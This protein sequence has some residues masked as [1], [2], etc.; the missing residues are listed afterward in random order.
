MNEEEYNAYS[1]LVVFELLTT[2]LKYLNEYTT[3]YPTNKSVAESFSKKPSEN[4]QS[5]LVN[6]YESNQQDVDDFTKQFIENNSTELDWTRFLNKYKTFPA[7]GQIFKIDKTAEA[8]MEFV[9]RMQAERWVFRHMSVAVE[10]D[11]Y[12]LFFA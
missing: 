12:V 2:S 5:T 8:Y 11:K 1:I 6:H 10:D 3:K 7:S 4:T 9:T